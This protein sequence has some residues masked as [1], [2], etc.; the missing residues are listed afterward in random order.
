VEAKTVILSAGK[1]MGQLLPRATD[2]KIVGSPLLVAYP[3]VTDRHFARMTPFVERSVNHLH[4]EIDGRRYSVIGGGYFADPSD[5]AS[6]ERARTKLRQMAEKVFPKLRHATVLESYLGYKTEIVAHAGERNYQ[7]IMREVEESVHAVIP[8]KFSLGF[9][10]AVNL[11]K[12]LTGTAPGQQVKLASR[13]K[14]DA[15]V[16]PMLHGA[17]VRRGLAQ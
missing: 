11:F 12:N 6:V 17:I 14:T 4:H 2:I 16:G 1:W 5:P 13:E 9:S 15:L 7:Y 10:L 3:A 8:G